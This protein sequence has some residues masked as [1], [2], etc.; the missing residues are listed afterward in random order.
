MIPT[1]ALPFTTSRILKLFVS[2]TRAIVSVED[3]QPR[4][5]SCGWGRAAANVPAKHTPSHH[6]KLNQL[7]CFFFLKNLLDLAVAAVMW[8]SIGWG[9]AFG[10]ETEYGEF[11]Q[12]AGPGSFFLRGG[13]FID[14]SGNYGTTEGYTWALWLFQVF[15][16]RASF[17]LLPGKTVQD[18]PAFYSTYIS[19]GW[20][21][22]EVSAMCLIQRHA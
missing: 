4:P 5:C 17:F 1:V 12:L 21:I 14:E 19:D 15:R 9:I 8:W 10:D 18:I 20:W 7:F 16:P 3:V 2:E 22:R 6:G 11:N 13:G